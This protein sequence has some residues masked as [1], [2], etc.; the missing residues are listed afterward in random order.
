MN[1]IQVRDLEINY[2]VRRINQGTL[3]V[4]SAAEARDRIAAGASG[5]EFFGKWCRYHCNPRE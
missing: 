1:L 2:Q 3:V 5:G 4:P